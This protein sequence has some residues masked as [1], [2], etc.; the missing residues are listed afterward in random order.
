MKAIILK[1]L[2]SPVFWLGALIIGLA[3]TCSIQHKKLSEK[4]EEVARLECNQTTLLKDVE[5]YRSKNGELVTSVNALTL[6]KDEL[7][8]LI[9]KYENEIRSLKIKLED[10]KSIAHIETETNV[11][12]SIPIADQSVPASEDSVLK[13]PESV[14]SPEQNVPAVPKEF[15]WKDDWTEISGKIYADSLSCSVTCRDSIT[16][17][18][19]Y[20][21]RKCL[22]KKKGKLIKYDVKSKNP[23]VTVKGVDVVELIEE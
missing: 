20:E 7:E 1:V 5:H 19:H 21:R 14:P 11:E 6:H 17:V 22:F 13:T 3:I 12:A 4:G 15:Y 18:A 16:L 2:K 9:P 8:T 23:H 10:A